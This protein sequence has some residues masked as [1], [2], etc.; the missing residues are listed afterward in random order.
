MEPGDSV[1]FKGPFKEPVS[2][3]AKVKNGTG[4]RMAFKVKCSDNDLFKIRPVMGV[5][6]D[7][8]NATVTLTFTAKDKK[9]PK[10]PHH[11]SLYEFE[12]KDDKKAARKAWED[13]EAKKKKRHKKVKVTFKDDDAGDKDDKKDDKEKKDDKDK[14]EDDKDKKEDD[15][16]EDDKDKKEDKKEEDD[17]KEDKKEEDDKKED[18]KE[19]EK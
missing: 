9:A 2:S 5:L 7:G 4:K 15:K 3:E 11:F 19:D 17:K 16:K 13:P 18:K 14:K 12:V 1:E 8:E 6:K 10:D